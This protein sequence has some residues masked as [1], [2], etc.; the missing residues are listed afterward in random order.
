MKIRIT[1]TGSEGTIYSYLDDTYKYYDMEKVQFG[2]WEA[3]FPNERGNSMA[4][5]LVESLAQS[6]HCPME[7]YSGEEVVKVKVELW[8]Q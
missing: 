6:D 1:F 7:F 2:E 8:K 5:G 3:P 4:Y